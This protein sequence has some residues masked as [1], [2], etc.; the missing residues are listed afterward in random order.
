MTADSANGEVG[1]GDISILYETEPPGSPG[2][3]H[4]VCMCH[5]KENVSLIYCVQICYMHK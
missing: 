2:T 1:F 5:L 3:A 4:Q